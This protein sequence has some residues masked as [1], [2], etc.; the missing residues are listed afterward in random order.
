MV[1]ALFLCCSK[2]LLVK[3]WMKIKCFFFL[4][5]VYVYLK[6]IPFWA[7][8]FFCFNKQH[9]HNEHDETLVY[10]WWAWDEFMREFSSHGILKLRLDFLMKCLAWVVTIRIVYS[11]YHYFL[12]YWLF[13]HFSLIWISPSFLSVFYI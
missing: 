1:S 4:V 10:A 8:N 7:M 5:D 12:E 3:M 13:H 11:V 9:L 6:L 2:V